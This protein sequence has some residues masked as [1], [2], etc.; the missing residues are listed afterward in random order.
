[1]IGKKWSQDRLKDWAQTGESSS[2]FWLKQSYLSA[3][4]ETPPQK[5]DKTHL[6]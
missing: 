4:W 2:L 5:K 3:G 6:I 1:M